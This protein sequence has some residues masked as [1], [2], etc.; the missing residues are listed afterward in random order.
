M[1]VLYNPMV[2]AN[3]LSSSFASTSFKDEPLA[4]T[5]KTFRNVACSILKSEGIACNVSLGHEGFEVALD[6]YVFDVYDFDILIGHPLEKLCLNISTV[7]ELNIR[8][9]RDSLA[10]PITCS[11]NSIAES[12]PQEDQIEKVLAVSSFE[13]SKTFLEEDAELFI[14][15]ED[16]LEETLD[17]PMHK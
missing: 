17:L 13:I 4:P 1:D 9:E 16:H 5:T 12:H 15:E 3:I 7:G 14:Q 6:F 2:G 8:F 11:T 10:I